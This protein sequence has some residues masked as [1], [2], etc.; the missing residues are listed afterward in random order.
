MRLRTTA[1]TLVAVGLALS[2]VIAPSANA[3]VLPN[4]HRVSTVSADIVSDRS[5]TGGVMHGGC[6]LA[7]AV[8]PTGTPNFYQGVIAAATVTTNA[9]S[10]PVNGEVKCFVE[11]NFQ[12]VNPP[13]DRSSLGAQAGAELRTFTASDSDIV[14]L[15]ED[16]WINGIAL[17]E[18]CQPVTQVTAPSQAIYDLID[19]L[20]VTT[21]DPLVC[22]ILQ[23]LYYM[24]ITGVSGVLEIGPDG[25]VSVADPLNLGLNPVEDCP[26]Y[27]I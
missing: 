24:G 8:D 5:N 20:S 18:V 10:V 23:N 21:I 14:E 6:F 2:V 19:T 3:R 12:Q 4:L 13:L 25:D 26:P 16:A 9:A 11:V 22:P 15:C 27:Q 17:S 1:A 7:A